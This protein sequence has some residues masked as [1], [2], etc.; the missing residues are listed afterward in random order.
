MY[1]LQK[2]F[3]T[4][5]HLIFKTWK[6]LLYFFWGEKTRSEVDF[7]K[8]SLIGDSGT[9]TSVKHSFLLVYPHFTQNYTFKVPNV[10]FYK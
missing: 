9:Q 7:S 10:L 5:T 2:A 8:V 4:L 3:N 1:N 6:F